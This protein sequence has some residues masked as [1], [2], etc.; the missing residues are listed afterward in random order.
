MSTSFFDLSGALYAQKNYL[1]DLQSKENDPN[2]TAKLNSTSSNLNN[3]YNNFINS[4]GTTNAVLA[5][6]IDMKEIVDTELNRLQQKKTNVDTA[7]EGQKRMVQL[8]ESYRQKY[9]YY[10]RG[11]VIVVVF[12]L[13]YI[14]ISVVS[15]Y[16]PDIPDSLFDVIYFILGVLFVFIIF[17]LYLDYSNRDNMDFSKLNYGPP[18]IPASANQIQEQQRN[19]LKM[20]DLLGSINVTGCI[21]DKCCSDGTKWDSGNSFCVRDGF[22]IMNNNSIGGATSNYASE[23]SEYTFI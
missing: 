13:L 4:S 3:L 20:G 8:N 22:T 16:L 12:L 21:G 9:L 23:T 7:L 10:T 1:L 5:N 2:L 17:F 14:I 18:N 6:Q 19:A 15:T 11:L